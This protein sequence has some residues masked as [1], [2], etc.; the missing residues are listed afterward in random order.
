MAKSTLVFYDVNDVATINTP[1]TFLQAN[2]KFADLTL[3]LRYTAPKFKELTSA[4]CCALWHK[5]SAARVPQ[6]TIERILES[7]RGKDSTYASR[8]KLWYLYCQPHKI[9]PLNPTYQR[10]VQFTQLPHMDT[11]TTTWENVVHPGNNP[12]L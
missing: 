10:C 5:Y 7:F 4:F 1:T 3:E 2:K 12:S 8:T 6:S 11:A 9:N